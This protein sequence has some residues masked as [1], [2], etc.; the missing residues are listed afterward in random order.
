MGNLR[1]PLE[2]EPAAPFP[3]L[4]EADL[5]SLT[6]LRLLNWRWLGDG[7]VECPCSFSTLPVLM[8][9]DPTVVADRA[10]IRRPAVFL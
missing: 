6:L 9:N 5:V 10:M 1:L 2:F 8:T 4:G 7:A 3:F